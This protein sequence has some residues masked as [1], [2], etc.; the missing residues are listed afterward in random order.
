MSGTDIHIPTL[1]T[2]RLILRAPHWADF[3]AYAA[4]CAGPRSAGV[5][6]PFTRD[7]SFARLS[8]IIGQWHLRGYGRW[9]ITAREGNEALGVSGIYYPEGWPEPE[10]AWTVFDTAEGKGIAYEAALAVRDY[11]A[12]AFGMRRLISCIVPENTRSVV[13]AERLGCTHE[14]VFQH[15]DY[16]DLNIWR[17]PEQAA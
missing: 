14:N 13:L 5:G 6:G 8:A 3:E 15:P 2:E 10:L 16:G 7:Q 11:A 9:M 17:H 4:Y 12:K 1:E